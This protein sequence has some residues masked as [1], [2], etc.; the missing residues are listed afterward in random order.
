MELSVE[1]IEILSGVVIGTFLGVTVHRSNYCMMGGV[2]DLVL[3]GST[4]RFR[5]WLLTI[6]VAIIGVQ[7]LTLTGSLDLS[8]TVYL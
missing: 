1:F 2:A 7:I 5:A 4:V 8:T 3:T 6:A